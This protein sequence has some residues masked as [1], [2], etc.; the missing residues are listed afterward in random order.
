MATQSSTKFSFWVAKQLK[1]EASDADKGKI[2][3]QT[4]LELRCT[5]SRLETLSSMLTHTISQVYV[6][7]PSASPPD[8]PRQYKIPVDLLLHAGVKPKKTGK[9][10]PAPQID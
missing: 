4:L 9:P 2:M 8:T 3:A 5:R 1:A 10:S 7:H 6:A